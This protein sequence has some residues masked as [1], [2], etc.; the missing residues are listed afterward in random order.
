MKFKSLLTFMVFSLLS[1]SLCAC[2]NTSSLLD[3]ESNSSQSSVKT[4]DE[5]APT[6]GYYYS[7]ADGF[8]VKFPDISQVR[9]IDTAEMGYDFGIDMRIYGVHSES[10]LVSLTVSVMDYP[11]GSLEEVSQRTVLKESAEMSSQS[12]E[13]STVLSMGVV[14]ETQGYPSIDY[15][16]EVVDDYLGTYRTYHR[17]ILV[18]YTMYHIKASGISES[19]AQKFIESFRFV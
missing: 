7:E 19:E 2:I 3:K 12:R 10:G 9:N 5:G 18:D 17:E 16:V 1:I 6:P 14:G 4:K 11:A 15:A 8:E 13:N